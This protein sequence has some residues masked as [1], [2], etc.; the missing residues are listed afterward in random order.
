MPYQTKTPPSKMTFTKSRF[1][2]LLNYINSDKIS[3]N[4]R[5]KTNNLTDKMLKYSM[6]YIKENGEELI[7]I[8]FYT[9]ELTDIIY[10]LL[11]NL[12]SSEPIKV[13][14]YSEVLKLK[15]EYKKSKHEAK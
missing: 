4:E 12:I 15:E 14:Y 7:N 5:N 3:E 2:Q 9:G 10:I 1:N 11:D 6:P 13:D 8:H